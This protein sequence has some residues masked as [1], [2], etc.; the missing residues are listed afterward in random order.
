MLCFLAA[1]QSLSVRAESLC[2]DR[3]IRF[4]HYEFGLLYSEGFGGIDDDIQKELERR[5]GCQFEVTLKPRARIWHELE[6]GNLDMAGSGVQTPERD[7]FAWFAHYVVEVNQVVLGKRV[8]DS[9]TDMESFLADDTLTMG[10]VR[11]FSYSPLY[12]GYV[13]K[14]DAQQ[15]FFYVN[16]TM[17]LYKMFDKGR[18]DAFIASQFLSEH[19]FKLLNMET[20]KRIETWDKS[21]GTPSGLVIARQSFT[22]EQGKGWQT[23]IKQMLADGTVEKIVRKHLGTLFFSDSVYSPPQPATAP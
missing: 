18:F 15:R 14:L 19:Y 16:N 3:P 23:L 4:A 7:K 20:P 12:D 10:G 1:S 21:G 22:A 17:S 5:S 8:P 2:P 6:T 9:V 11:S 13:E